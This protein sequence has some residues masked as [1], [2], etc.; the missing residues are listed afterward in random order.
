[1]VSH[2]CRNS[3]SIPDWRK[4]KVNR[5]FCLLSSRSYT[6]AFRV[7]VS[8]DS[9]I[10][11]H[12]TWFPVD[13]SADAWCSGT[14]DEPRPPWPT[15]WRTGPDSELSETANWKKKKKKTTKGSV[16]NKQGG[17]EYIKS[18]VSA[19]MTLMPA[20]IVVV[21][22]LQEPVI[23]MCPEIQ[24]SVLNHFTENLKFK[25]ITFNISSLTGSILHQSEKCSAE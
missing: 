1:M 6:S 21:F 23:S 8:T 19:Y 22:H 15:A 4:K 10:S 14:H 12:L 7:I 2:Q 16:Q 5:H 11:Q 3:A 17:R 20:T 9:W 18:R 13:P 25:F 24:S